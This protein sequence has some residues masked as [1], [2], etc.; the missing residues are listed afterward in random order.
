MKIFKPKFWHK[1]NS[2][3]SFLLLPISTFFQFLI[4]LN[5]LLRKK[6]KFSIPIISVGNIYLGGTG[7][8][9]LCIELVELLKKNNKKIAIVKKFYKAHEDEFKLIESKNITL[10]KN[11][12]RA[13]AI[14]EA[15]R[16]KFDC[17]ILDDGFQDQT[18][19]KDLNI[20]CFNEEQLAGNE[21]TLPSGPLREPLT[22]LKDAQI[23]VI[24]GNNN[25]DFN[26]RIKSISDDI[27]IYYSNYV[28]T[29]INLFAGQNLLAFAGIGNPDNF[30]NLLEKNNLKI[31]KKIYFPDHYDYSI[32]ELNNLID[33]SVKNN[34]KIITTE[35]DYFRIKH[36]NIS[37]IQYLSVKLEIKYKDK[38]EKEILECL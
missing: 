29:N 20:I 1:K 27:S 33:Y 18:I 8:T 38:F 28:P 24:N 13:L 26:K 11:S 34:L 22:S 12:S 5:K 21:M 25:E 16:N 9:P 35:K 19:F 15:E 36:Y 32:N 7:K 2:L 30:F 31:T 14:K 3:I 17:A 10:L 4:I 23:I 37:Q 6:K